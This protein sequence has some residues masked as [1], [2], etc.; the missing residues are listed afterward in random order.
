MEKIIYFDYAAILLLVILFITVLVKKMTRGRLNR[1]FLALLVCTFVSTFF[2]IWAI[3]LDKN[4]SGLI[5]EKYIIH[6]AYLLIHAMVAPIFLYYIIELT[7]TFFKFIEEKQNIVVM[8]IPVIFAEVLI[9][10]NFIHKK[11]FFVDSEGVYRRGPLM[12]SLYFLVGIYIVAGLFYLIVYRK[13]FEKGR[14]ISLMADIVFLVIAVC[15]QFVYPYLIVEMFAQTMGLL[16]IIL[17]I[18]KPED[19]LDTDTGI[20]KLSAFV[21][22][23]NRSKMNSKPERIIM[24]NMVNYKAVRDTLGYEET[25]ILKRKIADK[26]EQILIE[27]CVEG[28]LYYADGGR[29]RVLVNYN[30]HESTKGLAEAINKA[31]KTKKF[32]NDNIMM[33]ICVVNFPEDISNVDTLIAFGNDL[34]INSYTGE[35]LTASTIYEANYYDIKRDL[36]QIL[37]RAVINQTFEMYYQPIFNVDTGKF[38]S[39]EALVRLKDRKYGNI[40]PGFFIPMAEKSGAIHKITEVIIKKVCEFIK[41]DEF[42]HLGFDYVEVNLSIAHCMKRNMADEIIKQIR[43]AGVDF[44]KINFEITETATGAYGDIIVENIMKFHEAGFELSLDDFGIGYSNFQR[45]ASMP[46]KIIKFDRIFTGY[47]DN[48]QMM[49]LTEN[50]INTIKSMGYEVLIEGIENRE[51]LDYFIE[52]GCDYVQGYYYTRP[53]PVQQLVDYIDNYKAG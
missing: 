34:D 1:V 25:R 16:F 40:S 38:N 7:D 39:V 52:N 14:F 15:L 48:P 11:V 17:M 46:F 3:T 8:V 6:T 22:T 42:E 29:Y 5:L 24:V 43:D 19:R 18:Q 53:L 10:S 30:Q 41:S 45:L 23:L 26:L 27:N 9:C 20:S 44:S 37:E 50:L 12:T 33:C 35:V 2:D 28:E 31:F 13:E 51:L 47:I 49:L 36:D 4:F 21:E 32:E